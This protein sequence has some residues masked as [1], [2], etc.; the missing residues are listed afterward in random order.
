MS[1]EFPLAEE[2]YRILGTCFDVGLLVNFGHYPKLE[3]DRFLNRRLDTS[4]ANASRM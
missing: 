4:R 1:E 2:T 3:H